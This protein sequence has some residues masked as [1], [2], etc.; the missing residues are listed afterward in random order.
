M[1]SYY[2]KCRKNIE[3]KNS[4]IARTKKGRTTLLYKYAV[5]STNKW[6]TIKEFS[7][8]EQEFSRLLNSLGMQTPL[9]KIP[10][11]GSLLF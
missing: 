6:K 3:S 4:N 8:E 2:L 7:R 1:L 5:C 11:V 10:L 9:S